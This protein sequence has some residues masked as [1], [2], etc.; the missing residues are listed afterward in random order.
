MLRCLREARDAKIIRLLSDGKSAK[1]VAAKV[2]TSY[3]TVW[4]VAHKNPI[5]AKSKTFT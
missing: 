1:E 3:W 5:K 2:G 4:M